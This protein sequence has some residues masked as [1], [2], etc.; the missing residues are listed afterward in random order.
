MLV[1]T[2]SVVVN[3]LFQ[4]KVRG[5]M[6]GLLLWHSVRRLGGHVSAAGATDLLQAPSPNQGSDGSRRI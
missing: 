6:L 1:Q 3:L 4:P 5:R 2:P